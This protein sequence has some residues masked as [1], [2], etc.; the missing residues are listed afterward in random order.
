M[1]IHPSADDAG[2]AVPFVAVLLALG[3]VLAVALGQVGVLLVQ[4]AQART[5]ADAAALAGAE[6]GEAAARAMA[7]ANRAELVA[8]RRTGDETQVT[9]RVGTA[10]ATA[11]AER[12]VD[13]VTPARR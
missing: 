11:R 9:V 6:G 12:S 3:V 4:S 5:A 10:E 7:E 2:Q 8:Y 1:S 13:L